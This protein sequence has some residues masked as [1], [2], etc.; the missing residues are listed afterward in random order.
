MTERETTRVRSR[1]YTGGRTQMG[2]EVAFGLAVVGMGALVALTLLIVRADVPFMLLR[3]SAN[4][5]INRLVTYQ[6]A[7]LAFAVLVAALT[8]RLIPR[9]FRLYFR[10]GRMDAP[11]GP[12]RTLGIKGTETWKTLGISSSVVISLV[13]AMIVLLPAVKGAG[14]TLSHSL[15]VLA[16]L[17]AASN[18]F[19]EEYFTRF[20]VVASLAGRV[21]PGRIALIS[22]LLFGI[23]HYLGNPGQ[24]VGVLAASFLG[25]FLAKSVLETKG[26]GWAWVVHFLQDVIIFVAILGAP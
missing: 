14:L 25:W 3:V 23:P 7:T 15:A 20:Q 2:S 22:A 8:A 1:R 6:G 11:A 10:V 16:V 24:L 19:V 5:Q 18:A 26:L 17:L 12:V 21:G 13:T 9:S 4:D